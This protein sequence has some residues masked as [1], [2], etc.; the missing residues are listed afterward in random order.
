VEKRLRA[1][2][3]AHPSGRE[4]VR[5]WLVGL[6]R[7]D[8][9]AIGFDIKTVEE[10]WPVGPPLMDSLGGGLWEVRTNL[11]G[12]VARVFCC[13]RDGKL[14]LLHGIIKKTQK[15]PKHDLDVARSR[16]KAFMERIGEA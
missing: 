2:F 1:F 12:R 3:Y 16:Q 14:V 5:D 11:K 7:L 15:T 13:I 6:E 8:R 4:P 10:T 9:K